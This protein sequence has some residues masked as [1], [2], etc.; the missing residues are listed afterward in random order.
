[1]YI[2]FKIHIFTTLIKLFL[3]WF[4]W[5]FPEKMVTKNLRWNTRVM[6]L[7]SPFSKILMRFDMLYNWSHQSYEQ[8]NPTQNPLNSGLGVTIICPDVWKCLILKLIWL[9]SREFYSLFWGFHP[10]NVEIYVYI[11]TFISAWFAEFYIHLYFNEL[12]D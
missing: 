8:G 2:S 6:I 10:F 11:F 1:M 4:I 12:I 3:I 9:L 7:E 5:S